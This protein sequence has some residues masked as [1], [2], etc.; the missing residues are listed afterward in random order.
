MAFRCG[1][2]IS[3]VPSFK[4]EELQQLEKDVFELHPVIKVLIAASNGMP[5]YHKNEKFT[6]LVKEN[7][8]TIKD[9]AD[10]TGIIN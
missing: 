5:N 7:T 2:K 1:V 6:D 9:Y 4:E 10:S 8:Q 3:G